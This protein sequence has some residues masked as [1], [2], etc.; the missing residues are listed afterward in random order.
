MLARLGRGIL[1][2][3]PGYVVGA[4]VGYCLIIGLSSNMHDKSVEA[5][6]TSALII[7]PLCGLVAFT[8]GVSRAR[9]PAT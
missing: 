8:A 3:A 1:W 9:R 6:M 7:G 2:A 5:S 4:F